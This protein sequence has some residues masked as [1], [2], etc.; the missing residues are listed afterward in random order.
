M[1]KHDKTGRSKNPD[2]QFIPLTYIM[3]K[4]DAWRRLN[5]N[6]VRVFLELHM[7]FNGANNGELF[8]G[9]DQIAARLGISKSTVS[10][11]F[12]EL[13]EKGFIVKVKDGKWVRGQAAEWRITNKP[14]N[15]L[16]ATNDWKQWRKPLETIKKRKVYGSTKQK[17]LDYITKKNQFSGTE[18][19]PI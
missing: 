18:I 3:L 11:A 8:I 6:S 2:G 5:G 19:E 13:Q 7:R 17:H 9:M 16:P 15:K 1:G 12:K 14:T 10:G 4:S